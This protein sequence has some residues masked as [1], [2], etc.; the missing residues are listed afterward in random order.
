MPRKPWKP[1]AMPHTLPVGYLWIDMQDLNEQ[2][3]RKVLD[4]GF[5]QWGVLV[6][7]GEKKKQ[8]TKK[9]GKR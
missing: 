3:R 4:A 6:M 2:G 9:R 1:N 7:V 5:D 8:P